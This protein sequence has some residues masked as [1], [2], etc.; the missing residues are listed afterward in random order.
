MFPSALISHCKNTSSQSEK[1]KSLPPFHPPLL[2]TFQ[3]TNHNINNSKTTNNQIHNFD[4]F[5]SL[6]KD[7]GLD[8]FF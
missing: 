6:E 8:I 1:L 4:V 5:F 7:L 2:K 3:D